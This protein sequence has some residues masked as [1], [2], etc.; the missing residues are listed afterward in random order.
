MAK[1]VA[2]T[3]SEPNFQTSEFHIVGVTPYVQNRFSEKTK[4]MMLETQRKPG[5]TKGK[6]REPRKVEDEFEASIHYDE[7]GNF[8]IP[9]AAFRSSMID[10]CRAAGYQMTKAKMS[11]FCI[12]DSFDREDGTPLVKLFGDPERLDSMVRLESGVASISIRALWREWWAKPKI[13]WDADQF[14]ISDVANLLMRAGMQVGIGE[15][16]FFSKKSHGIGWGTFE[17][18]NKEDGNE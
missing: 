7:D 4:R 13:R 17:L 8:G 5:G 16:R 10:A 6:K 18:S 2:V 3:I 1:S 15:G 9:C 11:V 14:G 12:P